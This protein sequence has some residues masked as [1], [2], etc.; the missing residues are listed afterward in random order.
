MKGM[1]RR[2]VPPRRDVATG[3]SGDPALNRR[4]AA[5]QLALEAAGL[6][7]IAALRRAGIRPILLKGPVTTARLYP[8]TFRPYVDIDLIVPPDAYAQAVAV[9][10]GLG[11]RAVAAGPVADSFVRPG[12]GAM[13][14]LHRTLR[15]VTAAP[16]DAW[17][18]LDAHR[19]PF[20]LHGQEVEALDEGAFAF[21]LA[22]H[23]AQGG[24]AK[25]K[26]WLDLGRGLGRLPAQTWA[27]AWAVA[28][29]LGCVGPFVA[30]LR[31][32]GPAA[33]AVADGLDLP[34]WVPFMQH[35]LARRPAVGLR[36]VPAALR[37][38]AP[39]SLRRWLLPTPAERRR[40]LAL[41]DA[42]GLL[43][44]APPPVRYAVFRLEQGVRAG[45]ALAAAGGRRLVRRL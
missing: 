24:W 7:A 41:P 11:F 25:R 16:A 13:I 20:T 2:P 17:A 42:R 28:R 39:G 23:A 5:Q 38:E 27:E 19:A 26:A 45:H 9:L 29:A 21:H 10:A 1:L 22:L 15:Y 33:G 34:R 6:G 12:D 14:D 3:A 37:G 30:A 32:G 44:G 35:V 31:C 36:T 8:D 4:W 40:R 43:P 18:V